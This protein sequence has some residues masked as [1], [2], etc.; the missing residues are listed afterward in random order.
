MAKGR[1]EKVDVEYAVLEMWAAGVDS[2]LNLILPAF[3]ERL[4]G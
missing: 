4:Y 1:W 2:D 3:L